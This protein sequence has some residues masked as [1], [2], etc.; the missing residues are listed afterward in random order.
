M[1]QKLLVSVIIPVYNG[2]NYL[3]EAINSVF[4]QTYENVEIIVVDDGST[5][6]TWALIESCNS[7]IRSFKKE[8]GGTASA[9]NLGIRNAFGDFI[10]WLSHDDLFMPEKL[11]KQVEF[12]IRNPQYAFSYTDYIIIDSNGVELRKA[13]CPYYEKSQMMRQLFCEN[14]IRSIM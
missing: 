12:M 7:K 9:L 8:N 14:Y 13:N 3:Q 6:G 11:E 1:S 4:A 5:D 2:I 10:S